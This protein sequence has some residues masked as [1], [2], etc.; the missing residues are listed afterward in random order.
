MTYSTTGSLILSSV[1]ENQQGNIGGQTT[2]GSPLVGSGPFIGTVSASNSIHFTSTATDGSGLTIIF[3][4]TVNLQ[5]NSM[6]GNYTVYNG[7]SGIQIG[8]WQMSA[9]S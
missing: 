8:T 9:L 2:W 5:N 3:T 1:I 4:G 6:S 7:S